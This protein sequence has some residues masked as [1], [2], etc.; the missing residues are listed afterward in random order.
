MAVDP[1][2]NGYQLVAAFDRLR[3]D[4]REDLDAME[5]RVMTA[6]DGA[7]RQLGSYQTEHGREHVTMRGES[8]AA[9][10]RFDEFIRS[11]AL[12]QARKDGAL[13][14]VRFMADIAGRNWKA[15]LIL[16]GT[17]LTIAGNVQIDLGVR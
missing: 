13:G 4:F 7:T 3:D 12:S 15:L 5:K 16:A 8:E 1:P 9:H 6:I 2:A 10:A 17:L 14:V 11:A